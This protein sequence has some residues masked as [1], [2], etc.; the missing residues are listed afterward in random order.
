MKVKFIGAIERVTGSC[1]L[2]EHSEKGL[3][4]LIDCG[5]TQ[6]EP[7]SIAKNKQ[8]WPFTASRIDFVLLTHAHL[9]HCGLLPR[10]IREG[11]SGLIYGTVANSRW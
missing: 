7:N 3:R 8:Q 9:D 2:M 1:T 4:F 5:M 11:F 10:L 6:G